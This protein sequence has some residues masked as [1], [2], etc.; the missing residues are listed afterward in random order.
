MSKNTAPA[1]ASMLASI[2]GLLAVSSASFAVPAAAPAVGAS[3]YVVAP[4][5]GDATAAKPLVINLPDPADGNVKVNVVVAKWD[6]TKETFAQ[7]SARKA[8][9]IAAAVNGDPAAA[10]AGITANTSVVTAK[11]VTGFKLDSLTNRLVPVIDDVPQYS[12]INYNGVGKAVFYAPDPTRETGGRGNFQ[13]VNPG[14]GG[15]GTYPSPGYMPSMGRPNSITPGTS[16]GTG[17][18]DSSDNPVSDNFSDLTNPILGSGV[19]AFGYYL[20]DPNS[21]AGQEVVSPSQFFVTGVKTTAGQS[22]S[23]VLQDVASQW[24][25]EFSSLTGNSVVYDSS[26]VSISL[27]NAISWDYSWLAFNTDDGLTLEPTIAAVPEPATLLVVALG[28][29]LLAARR[30]RR[31]VGA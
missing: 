10:A 1:L 24:N 28:A 8:A 23:Q 31:A 21:P 20:I 3:T 13:K 9:A 29:G 11:A 7:A 22:D 26:S 4:P 25:S 30:R 15:T 16:S 14:N 6:P 12:K 19:V 2:G 18:R 5:N 17:L 27:S